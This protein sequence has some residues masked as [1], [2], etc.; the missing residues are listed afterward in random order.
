MVRFMVVGGA[1]SIPEC[2]LRELD[3]ED[4]DLDADFGDLDLER[5]LP[6]LLAGESD[7]EADLDR[8]DDLEP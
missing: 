7:L 4:L 6:G 3:L 2:E 1:D 8:E 5:V